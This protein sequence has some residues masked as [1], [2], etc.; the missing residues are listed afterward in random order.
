MM[1]VEQLNMPRYKVVVQSTI[2]ELKDQGVRIASRCL[3][4]TANDNYASVSYKNVSSDAKL[5]IVCF[6]GST[7]RTMSLHI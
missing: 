2:G 7:R 4:D 5:H 1:F 6:S 3:W